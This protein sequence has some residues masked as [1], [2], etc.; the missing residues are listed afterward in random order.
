MGTPS[1]APTGWTRRADGTL[2]RESLHPFAAGELRR[3]NGVHA[4][5]GNECWCNP[6]RTDGRHDELCLR[7]QGGDR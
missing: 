2:V 6:T 1:A 5:D 4:V 7:R 3:R